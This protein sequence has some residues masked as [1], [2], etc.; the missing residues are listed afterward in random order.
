MP[1]AATPAPL[2][3]HGSAPVQ[4]P[5]QLL[6]QMVRRG[7]S[8]PHLQRALAALRW[9]EELLSGVMRPSLKPISTHGVVVAGL[10]LEC[11]PEPDV[12]IA[13][14]LHT[15][16]Q[17]PLDDLEPRRHYVLQH[18]GSA[19]LSLLEQFQ[20]VNMSPALWQTLPPNTPDAVAL[21]RLADELE[22]MFDGE[23]HLHGLHSDT[24]SEHG[25]TEFV[26]R[27]FRSYAPAYA[28]AKL[29]GGAPLAARYQTLLQDIAHSPFPPSLRTG[30]YSATRERRRLLS[31]S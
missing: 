23:F 11:E 19:I 31:S 28:E 12:A 10:M 29:R 30:L 14:I 26:I 8:E 4:T 18:F 20:A 5:A 16:L 7:Y 3:A 17:A 24:G 9:S 2:Q 25:S 22:C 1:I 15:C 6:S 13:A 21:I 27:R